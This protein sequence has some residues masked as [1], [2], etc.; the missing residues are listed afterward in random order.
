MKKGPNQ[1]PIPADMH[2]TVRHE[3]LF[4]LAEGLRSAGEISRKVRISEREV[5][6]HL[7]HIRK[8]ASKAG[9][10]LVITPAECRK[11]GFVFTKRERFRKP[12]RC[13]LCRG[14]SIQEALFAISECSGKRRICKHG[15]EIGG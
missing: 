3:I 5:Y 14:E 1:P 4:V 7:E 6:G 12:G 2:D 10:R 11:C 9:K 13:P 8:T 15:H